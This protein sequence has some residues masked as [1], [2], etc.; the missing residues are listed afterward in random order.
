MNDQAQAQVIE[1]PLQRLSRTERRNWRSAERRARRDHDAEQLATLRS[2]AAT[3]SG[4]TGMRAGDSG[5]SGG[6]LT[7]SVEMI[8][9]GRRL[10]A[11]R[12]YRP[13]V[14]ALKEALGSIA[15]VPL[16]AVGRYGPY[17]VLTFKLATE[18]LVLLVE[19][20]TILP[21]WGGTSMRLGVPTG[22]IGQLVG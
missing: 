12:V 10:R 13:A 20:L 4:V 5:D 6:V 22:P 21:D 14:G 7:D 17:W 2:F 8:I 19:R 18:P 15:S 16:T 9:D 3:G 1:D 11:A